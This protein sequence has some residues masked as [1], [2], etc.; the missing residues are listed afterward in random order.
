MVKFNLP[1][2]S[3]LTKG[4]YFKSDSGS[5]DIK[6]FQIYRWAP[7]DKNWMKHTLSWLEEKSCKID[8]RSVHEYTLSNEVKYI[9]PKA[10]VY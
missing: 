6:K 5:N 8:Y 7:D 3:K 9:E 1:D 4:D 10:R 2:N